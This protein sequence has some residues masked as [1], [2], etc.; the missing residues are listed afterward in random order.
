MRFPDFPREE[1]SARQN[2]ARTLMDEKGFDALLLTTENN[3]RYLSGHWTQ[4][5]VSKT[6]PM[7]MLLPLKGDPALLVSGAELGVAKSTSW[8][9]DIRPSSG[10]AK[11]SMDLLIETLEEFG[12]TESTI[13]MELGVEQRL[14]L[15][16]NDF[17][18]LKKELPRIKV[19]DAADLL[20][21]LRQVKSRAEIRWM[22]QAASNNDQ[23]VEEVLGS[24]KAGMTEEE[25]YRQ[26]CLKM[27]EY[28]NKPGY[29]PITSG[30]GNYDRVT[31]GPTDRTFKEGD[32]IWV[33]NCSTYKGYWVDYCRI[34]AIGHA[35]QEQKD[36]YKLVY[37]VMW[38][39]IDAV[40]PGIPV[41]EIMRV[42]NQE[43]E[44][45]GEEQSRVGRM[46]HSLG[47][48]LTEP[49]S[50][51]LGDHTL[52][53]PGMVLAIEPNILKEYGYFQLEED[54]VVTEAGCE[55]ISHPAEETLPLR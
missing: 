37:D 50:L 55:V 15:P 36:M 51:T 14:G 21:T 13:G 54:V 24:V 42:C 20:W 40:K 30:G 34:L 5:W 28:G 32:L 45:A 8:V 1:I 12:L 31:G 23:A 19:R 6:R 53:E 27:T 18:R 47:L 10:F 52:I 16:Y 46:G 25:L 17:L 11:E 48:D 29:I 49:P 26:L 41:S 44:K 2:K 33:D 43:F 39:C 3:Y 9:E 4:F 38:K 35:T 7:F 22:K